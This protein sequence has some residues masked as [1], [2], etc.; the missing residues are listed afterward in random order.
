MEAFLPKRNI[1]V[2]TPKYIRYYNTSPINQPNVTHIIIN[3]LGEAKYILD[4]LNKK[5]TVQEE[6]DLVAFAEQALLSWPNAPLK[7]GRISFKIAFADQ[8]YMHPE[9]FVLPAQ[10]SVLKAK[11][12]NKKHFRILIVNGFGGNLGDSLVGLSAFE[13]VAKILEKELGSF[14]VD[15]L[16]GIDANPYN[17][18]IL[19]SKP[20][21]ENIYYLGPSLM[22]IGSYDAYFDTS[23]LIKL[24]NYDKFN[25]FDWYL[26]WFGLD[27]ST[28][29]K[30]KKRNSLTIHY[31]ANLFVMDLLKEVKNK[32][33]LFV[34]KASVELRSMPKHIAAGF[35]KNLLNTA[36]DITLIV[37]TTLGI[38]HPRL[39]DLDGKIDNPE[40]FK[41]LCAQVDGIITIDSFSLHVADACDKPTVALLSST[42]ANHYSNYP[43]TDFIEIDN[44]RNLPAFGKVKVSE[45]EFKEIEPLYEKSWYTLNAKLVWEKLLKKLDAKEIKMPRLYIIKD[46][47]PPAFCSLKDTIVFKREK[48]N[49]LYNKVTDLFL[50]T[51]KMLLKIGSISVGACLDPKV[52]ITAAKISSNY[53]KVF[54][55]EP[56]R[57]KFQALCG[58]IVLNNC[59]NVF[60]IEAICS[61]KNDKLSVADFNPLSESDPFS[62]GNVP[63]LV[64]AQTQTI[65]SLNLDYCNL[66]LLSAPADYQT[67]LKGAFS[68]IEQNEPFI[69]FGP[70]AKQ[71]ILAVCR[72]LEKIYDFWALELEPNTQVFFVV[73]TPKKKNITINGF[74]K[75]NLEGENNGENAKN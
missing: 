16:L 19:S 24:P 56:R 27:P 45:E 2:D 70:I 10:L 9:P 74:L 11:H 43:F 31:P 7:I 46:I 38:K 3:N 26:W 65:D 61:D 15:I 36:K 25:R 58:S 55:Y 64:D 72:L 12:P 29:E 5:D 75:I 63:K 34:H 21:I 57:L 44:A 67:S 40:K 73:S 17:S 4:E 71:N 54:A 13:H 47:T 18:F 62:F 8:F 35:A 28:I 49:N 69:A 41:A 39:L 22:D 51:T 30:E 60:T 1:L 23:N 53:G 14:S 59:S 42:T 6:K 20:Y 66:I 33:I 37:D 68:C 50:N 32:K 48:E 52:Y